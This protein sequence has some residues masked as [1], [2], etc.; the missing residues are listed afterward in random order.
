ML[1]GAASHEHVL[2]VARADDGCVVGSDRRDVRD[3][4]WHAGEPPH[5]HEHCAIECIPVHHLVVG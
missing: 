1:C 5:D 4:R 2:H 3:H